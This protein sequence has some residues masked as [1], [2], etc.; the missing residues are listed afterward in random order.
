MSENSE[1]TAAPRWKRV[2]EAFGLAAGLVGSLTA[3][4]TASKEMIAYVFPLVEHWVVSPPSDLVVSLAPSLSSAQVY[5]RILMDAG[6]RA[7]SATLD[8]IQS[9]SS[10]PAGLVIIDGRLQGPKRIADLLRQRPW[11]GAQLIGMGGIGS[12]VISDLDPDTILSAIEYESNDPVVFGPADLPS[13]L[14]AG[15]PPDHPFAVYADTPRDPQTNA[16][17]YDSHSLAVL[18]ALGIVRRTS[19]KRFPCSGNY[20]PVVQQGR[21]VF[22]GYADD[23]QNLTT[24]GKRLLLN[25]VTYLQSGQARSAQTKALE[26]VQAPPLHYSDKLDCTG[27]TPVDEQQYPFVVDQPGTISVQVRSKDALSLILNGPH[28]LPG[29][30]NAFRRKDGINPEVVYTVTQKEIG[31]GTKWRARV[32]SFDMKPGTKISYMI[33]IDYPLPRQLHPFIWIVIGISGLAMF[34]IVVVW[35]FKRFRGVV[36]HRP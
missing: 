35:G 16:A 6:I 32:M 8:E 17:V 13:K 22:W 34:V 24:E 19:A 9:L 33:T 23:P 4:V 27:D 1:T 21:Y 12:A 25:I 10:K 20:W 3:I 31:L 28:G 18:G 29:Q 26:S 14:T 11:A 2:I 15:V 5:T 36:A 30:F 7:T